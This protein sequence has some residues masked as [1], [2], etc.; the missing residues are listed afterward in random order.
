[1]R[2]PACSGASARRTRIRAVAGFSCWPIFALLCVVLPHVIASG[3]SSGSFIASAEAKDKKSES[4]KSESSKS[5]SS[6]SESSE[7]SS[8]SE[9]SE[10][11]EDS[12]HS[13]HSESS[14]RSDKSEDSHSDSGSESKGNSSESK[15]ESREENNERESRETSREYGESKGNYG[16]TGKKR[17]DSRPPKTVKEMLNRM[18]GSE[19]GKGGKGGKPRAVAPME[20]IGTRTY[21]NNEVL[22]VNLSPQGQMRAQRMGFTV[23]GHSTFGRGGNMVRLGTPHGMGALKAREVLV[24]DMPSEQFALNQ[25]YRAYHIANKDIGTSGA[26]APAGRGGLAS[27]SGDHCFAR[28]VIRWHDAVQPCAKGLR[29]GVIDT[30]FDQQHPAFAKAQL[31]VGGFVPGER[32]PAP[33]WHGT[34]VLALLAGSPDSGT[35]GLIPQAKFYVA[36]VFFEDAAG[37]VATDTASVL[38]AL[39]WMDAFDVKVVNMSFS[40]PKDELIRKTIERMAAKGVLFVAAAGNDG[41]TAEP[42]YP[43]AYKDVV[44]VTAVTKELR[45]YAYANRGERIDVAAPGVNIWSAVPQG[46]EGYHTGTSFAAPYVTAMLATVYNSAEQKQKEEFINRLSIMDLGTPGRDPVYGRGLALAPTK[47]GMPDGSIAQVPAERQEARTMPVAQP[48]PLP[49]PGEQGP[50]I[51]ITPSSGPASGP[52]F[53]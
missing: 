40:G 36:N 31:S 39:D 44:A 17:E 41:P 15:S 48:Q 46:R 35:P 38:N 10:K 20:P 43:A 19:G 33:Q 5:E 16:G 50:G 25:V 32:K 8:K 37:D 11:S 1:M 51:S 42:S 49:Q 27:C 6:K 9:K 13:E 12:E 14:E 47:C 45:N 23:Q 22:A 30:H 4:S 7:R 21:M 18:I 24:R 34:G 3:G 26:T 53:R 29:V 52:A 28:Q 2:R